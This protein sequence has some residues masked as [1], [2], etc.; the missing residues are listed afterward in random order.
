MR[1]LKQLSGSNFE[2]YR[3]IIRNLRR[4]PRRF[5]NKRLHE[6]A[7]KRGEDD[8]R[9]TT[10]NIYTE[11]GSAHRDSQNRVSHMQLNCC[12]SSS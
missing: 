8:V 5:E 12:P 9:I 4:G 7:D 6:R 3:G 2:T 11:E 10:Q 1:S